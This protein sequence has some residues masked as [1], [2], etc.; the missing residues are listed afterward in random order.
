MEVGDQMTNNRLADIERRAA[1]ATPGPWSSSSFDDWSF[2]S[3][4]GIGD[5]TQDPPKIVSW[6]EGNGP[7]GSYY[8][9]PGKDYHGERIQTS[10]STD[11]DD[12]FIA[13]ARQDIPYLLDLVKEQRAEIERL[14]ARIDYHYE[15]E[16]AGL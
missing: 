10:S 5:F 14:R 6:S 1:A 9:E 15:T 4:Y 7:L 11:E 16:R 2:T 3:N 8:D 13:H 12:E